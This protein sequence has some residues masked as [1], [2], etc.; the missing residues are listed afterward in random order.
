MLVY[1]ESASEMAVFVSVRALLY[2]CVSWD[3]N[4]PDNVMQQS[5]D[6]HTSQL[7]QSGSW[8]Q[9]DKL[10][11]LQS[12]LF[13]SFVVH[14][15]KGIMF[16]LITPSAAGFCLLLAGDSCKIL[17]KTQEHLDWIN[18]SGL[19]MFAQSFSLRPCSALLGNC[20]VTKSIVFFWKMF[21]LSYYFPGFIFWG[22]NTQSLDVW[23]FTPAH[24]CLQTIQQRVRVRFHWGKIWY[25]Q[26][27]PTEKNLSTYTLFGK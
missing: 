24:Q 3:S 1:L 21:K 19:L 6:P 11:W 20:F 25:T 16:V 26:F 14:N 27:G 15:A 12:Q 17:S 7:S 8:L 23:N 18:Y 2:V 22:C 10:E 5:I 9:K 13:A 4:R